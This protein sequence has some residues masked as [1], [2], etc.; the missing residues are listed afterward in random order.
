MLRL[1][2]GVAQVAN[3]VPP[4]STDIYVV[5][6]GPAPIPKGAAET[7]GVVPF[8]VPAAPETSVQVMSSN[9]KL[10]W[11]AASG[12][13]YCGSAG[14]S[15]SVTVTVALAA[16]VRASQASPVVTNKILR[17]LKTPKRTVYDFRSIITNWLGQ[18]PFS[19]RRF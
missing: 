9:V 15:F 18:L 14:P 8:A 2:W 12:A 6:L 10:F 17:M 19:A 5:P 11:P 3:S 16:P 4:P 13:K 7:S 1:G